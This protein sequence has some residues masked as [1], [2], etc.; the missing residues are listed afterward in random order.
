[1]SD[2]TDRV[3]NE[4]EGD[5]GDVSPVLGSQRAPTRRWGTPGCEPRR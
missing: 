2:G 5:N 3:A 1:M 4:T